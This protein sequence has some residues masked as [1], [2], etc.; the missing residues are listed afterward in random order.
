MMKKQQGFTLIELMIVV[1]II[2][3]L[4]AIA[5]PA[6]QDYTVRSKLSEGP[7]LLN[8]QK[9]LVEQ[10]WQEEAVLPDN[11]ASLAGNPSTA[12]GSYIQNG[13]V[14][15]NGGGA[16]AIGSTV[17]VAITFDAID[18]S[19]GNNADDVIFMEATVASSGNLS[20]TVGCTP[21]TIADSRC[22]AR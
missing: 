12:Y 19:V 15:I 3:I 9:L 16:S 17:S 20:W 1:A 18:T 6:Y 4:A 10:Y 8:K 14:A 13:T 5:L 22:P 11:I 2:G 21:A 7:S